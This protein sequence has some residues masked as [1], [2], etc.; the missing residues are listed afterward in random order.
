MN[1]TKIIILFFI[2]LSFIACNENL[3][4]NEVDVEKYDY[5]KP[6]LV[7]NKTDFKGNHNIDS[8]NFTFSYEVQNIKRALNEIDQK[9]TEESWNRSNLNRNT[10]SYSKEI[11]IFKSTLSVIVVKIT[12]LENDERIYFKVK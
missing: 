6:F 7:N 4:L 11:E 10:I 2:S 9:A 3:R 8:E 1:T 5:L 12:I